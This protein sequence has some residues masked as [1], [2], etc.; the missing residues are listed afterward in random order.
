MKVKLFGTLRTVVG[1]KEAKVSLDQQST[2]RA[3]LDQL[4]AT[5]PELEEK[6]GTEGETPPTGVNILVNGRSIEFLDGFNTPLQ[7]DDR[8]A[9]F[10]P[11][12]GG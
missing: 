5:Y 3:V 4:M 2:V 9:L 10:P 6:L 12:G 8:V 1:D 7:E 11:L